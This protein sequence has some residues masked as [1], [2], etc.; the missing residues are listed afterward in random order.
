MGSNILVLGSGM[1]ARPGIQY[2][3]SKGHSVT[4]ASNEVARAKLYIGSHPNG[5]AVD[6]NVQDRNALMALVRNRNIVISLL[7]PTL[8]PVVAEACIE[9]GTDMVT[10]SYVSSEMKALHR[11]A[12]DRDVILLNEIGVD[13]GIDHMSAMRIIHAAQGRGERVTAFR[14]LC[15][16]LP[17]PNAN[18]NP[19]GYKFSWRPVGV[20]NAMRSEAKYLAGG[21]V[22]TVPASELFAHPETMEFD[23]VGKLESHPNRDSLGYRGIYGIDDV[24]TM[25]RGT[26]RY[27][28]WCEFWDF[29]IKI[30]L[31]DQA[32]KDLNNTT[33]RNFFLAMLDASTGSDIETLLAMRLGVSKE[34]EQFKS[35]AQ[36]LEWLG[37]LS[38]KL[39]PTEKLES[40]SNFH[41]IADL[42]DRNSSL[43]YQEGERD[44][45]I[46]RH[47]FTTRSSTRSRRM[48]STLVDYGIP[49]GDT[50]MARTVSLPAA[51]AAELIVKEK[52]NLPVRG[53]CLP[54]I[55]QIYGPVLSGLERLGIIMRDEEQG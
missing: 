49:G 40:R 41:V 5:K 50:S 51:I 15:G 32:Q 16:G 6:L 9:A 12:E 8:H 28:G 53:V 26:L 39:I 48:V 43:W 24:E 36:I 14:S 47:E 37:L 11:A 44:M 21:H 33:Y 31:L 3:L 25:F 38:E 29:A 46:M 42:L 34:D 7:P 54:I 35:F 30:G 18:N 10:S 45:L 52:G 23:G 4:V 27:P 22:M 19:L 20:L 17:A 2:L 1:V 13:P 55:P